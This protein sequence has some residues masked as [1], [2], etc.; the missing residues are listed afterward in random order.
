MSTWFLVIFLYAPNGEYID[1]VSVPM[2]GAIEQQC[3]K[4]RDGFWRLKKPLEGMDK[5]K[6]YNLCVTEKHWRGLD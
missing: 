3:K 6:P 4:D 1:K 5:I 2:T